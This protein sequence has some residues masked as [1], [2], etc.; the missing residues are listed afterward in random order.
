MRSKSARYGFVAC[1][2]CAL[3]LW[4]GDVRGKGDPSLDWKSIESAH[5]VI[6]YPSVLEVFARYSLEQAELAH[7]DL[8]GLLDWVPEFKTHIT[9]SDFQDSANGWATILPTNQMHLY[10]YPPAGFGELGDYDDWI[11]LL[12]YHEYTHILHMD[13]HFD[14]R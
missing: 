11:R 2:I 7:R 6:H 5:F 10:A 1:L 14:I 4:C 9:V 3:L 12:V 13:V 8:S